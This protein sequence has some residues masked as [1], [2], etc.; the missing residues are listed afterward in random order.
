[1]RVETNRFVTEGEVAAQG[2]RVTVAVINSSPQSMNTK[3]GS[4]QFGLGIRAPADTG[5]D[6]IDG[7]CR[8]RL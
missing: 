8:A 4:V 1:M 2:G 7:L 5:V 6:L 3:A